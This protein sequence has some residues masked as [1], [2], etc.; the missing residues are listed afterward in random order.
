MVNDKNHPI[1]GVLTWTLYRETCVLQGFTDRFHLSREPLDS[2]EPAIR[3]TT[4]GT[5]GKEEALGGW[6]SM[7]CKSPN[8]AKT[9]QHT[10]KNKHI[11]LAY[12][13]K[14]ISEI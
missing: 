5:G 2:R 14:K 9:I 8:W 7:V 6:W 4:M 3:W 11:K 12:Y 13:T 1:A 10:R